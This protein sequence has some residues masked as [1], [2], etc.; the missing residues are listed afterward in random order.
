MNNLK[1]L[2][3]RKGVTQKDIAEYLGVT[4]S[5]YGQYETGSRQMNPDVISRLSDYFNVSSDVILGRE[6]VGG[7]FIRE[8]E[9]KPEIV[10]EDEVMI[11]VVASLRC[12]FGQC[13]EPFTILKRIPVP[14]SY[15]SRWGKDIVAVEAVGK[16]MLPTIQP[17]ALLIVVPGSVWQ[18]NWIVVADVN[19]S[20]TIKRIFRNHDDGGI[21]LIPDNE[22]FKVMHFTAKDMKDYQISILGHVVKA[23]SPDL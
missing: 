13:G 6:T 1:I 19:D 15:V 2:R 21:D 8:I 14:K 7:T 20:D 12:G 16:S 5:A 23:I 11:P 17:G 4:T 10:A 18:D 3:K 22:N 9:V